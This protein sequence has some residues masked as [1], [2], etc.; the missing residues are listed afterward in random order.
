MEEK[1]KVGNKALATLD[2]YGYTFEKVKAFLKHQY[3][4]SDCYLEDI[5]RSFA[6]DLRALSFHRREFTE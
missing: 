3:K 4:I 5:K 6:H 1:V 2:K